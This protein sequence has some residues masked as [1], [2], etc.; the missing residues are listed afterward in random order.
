[1]QKA[2]ALLLTFCVIR[3]IVFFR[4]QYFCSFHAARAAVCLLH[5][6]PKI[7]AQQR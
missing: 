7:V 6:L 5:P 2:G 4:R 1:M 3:R